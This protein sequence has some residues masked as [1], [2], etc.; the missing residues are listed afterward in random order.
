VLEEGAKIGNDINLSQEA[1]AF[2]AKDQELKF[3]YLEQV[4]EGVWLL[5]TIVDIR[6]HRRSIPRG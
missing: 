3:Q 1:L 6:W 4:P 2:K 5:I